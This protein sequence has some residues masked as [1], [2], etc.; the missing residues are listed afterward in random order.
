VMGFRKRYL[1][2]VAK[3]TTRG[4]ITAIALSVTAR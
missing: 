4:R 3:P 2:V 1:R